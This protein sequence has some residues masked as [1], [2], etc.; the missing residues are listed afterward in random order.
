[1]YD[2][3]NL[4]RQP[5]CE[6]R[7]DGPEPRVPQRAVTKASAQAPPAIN[8]QPPISTARGPKRATAACTRVIA[9]APMR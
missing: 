3:A 6:R 9:T 8:R 5:E 7:R 4:R 2:E 1:M